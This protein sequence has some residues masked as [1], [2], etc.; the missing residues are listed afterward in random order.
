[1]IMDNSKVW[2][3]EGAKIVHSQYFTAAA[4]LTGARGLGNTSKSTRGGQCHLERKRENEAQRDSEIKTE[5]ERQREREEG[6]IAL[7]RSLILYIVPEKTRHTREREARTRTC[8]CRRV[9]TRRCSN[10]YLRV[11]IYVCTQE[12]EISRLS[13]QQQQQR[14]RQQCARACVNVILLMTF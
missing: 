6:R 9:G 13:V 5:E 7:C 10:V 2:P 14:R 12:D 11:C 4:R 3:H 8:D 1:M